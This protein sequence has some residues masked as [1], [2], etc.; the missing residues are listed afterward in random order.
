MSSFGEYDTEENIY[1]LELLNEDIDRMLNLDDEL[2]D[3]LNALE[4]VCEM[5]STYEY[6]SMDRHYGYD[7]EDNKYPLELLNEDIDRMLNSDEFISALNAL[8]TAMEKEV[9]N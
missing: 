4:K 2:N 8:K 5:V 3:A 6:D 7:T 9:D 1:P